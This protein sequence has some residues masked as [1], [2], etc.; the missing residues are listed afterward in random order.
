MKAWICSFVAPEIPH[1][2]GNMSDQAYAPRLS[3]QPIFHYTSD[4]HPSFSCQNASSS[5]FA[6]TQVGFMQALHF[7]S[8]GGWLSQ[9]KAQRKDAFTILLSRR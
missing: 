8:V 9:F 5:A 6:S 2:G 4:Q 3:W 1:F 7:W